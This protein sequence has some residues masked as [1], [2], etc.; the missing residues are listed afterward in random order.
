MP[1]QAPTRRQAI[2]ERDAHQATNLFKRNKAHIIGVHGTQVKKFSEIKKK[3]LISRDKMWSTFYGITPQRVS[4]I[5][6]SQGKVAAYRYLVQTLEKNLFHVD[7]GM[8]PA[9]EIENHGIVIG[10]RKKATI[11]LHQDL[12]LGGTGLGGFTRRE[13]VGFIQ[14]DAK[15]I[16]FLKKKYPE[17]EESI[18]L[19][20]TH[21]WNNPTPFQH[22]MAK[23]L[24]RNMIRELSTRQRPF[25]LFG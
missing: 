5:I 19:M 8:K 3:G 17:E 6:H 12:P 13:I 20:T 23:M 11:D 16:A 2:R 21:T 22:D 4:T 7:K 9:T 25:R 10:R 14:L 15:Q 24:A 18:P 1:S